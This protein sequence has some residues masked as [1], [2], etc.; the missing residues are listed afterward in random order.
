M[1]DL[2]RDDS[3]TL[4]SEKPRELHSL[5][6]ASSGI[7]NATTDDSSEPKRHIIVDRLTKTCVRENSVKS[8]LRSKTREESSDIQRS[9]SK[10]RNTVTRSKEGNTSCEKEDA[11]IQATLAKSETF[12]QAKVK[13]RDAS[14]DR[15]RSKSREKKKFD[16]ACEQ[17]MK[18]PEKVSTVNST[19]NDEQR[20]PRGRSKSQ[21]RTQSSSVRSP[22]GTKAEERSTS[23]KSTEQKIESTTDLKNDTTINTS[24]NDEQ[25]KSRGRSKS[26]SRPKSRERSKSSVRSSAS[27]STEDNERPASGTRKEQKTETIKCRGKSRSKSRD[28]RK[29]SSDGKKHVIRIKLGSKDAGLEKLL[30]TK[31]DSFRDTE[32]DILERLLVEHRLLMEE[33][34]TLS[35]A[36][37][38]LTKSNIELADDLRQIR[39]DTMKVRLANQRIQQETHQLEDTVLPAYRENVSNLESTLEQQSCTGSFE[40]S[41]R[42]LYQE[43]VRKMCKKVRKRPSEVELSE[44]IKVLAATEMA[45]ADD[46]E[47]DDEAESCETEEKFAAHLFPFDNCEVHLWDDSDATGLTL[48]E[49]G[50]YVDDNSE[51]GVFNDNDSDDDDHDSTFNKRIA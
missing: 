17:F 14:R 23:E 8:I 49:S 19:N 24:K 13:N 47:E 33:Q 11:V 46:L 31:G 37:D 22:G 51:S 5:R 35:M 2:R 32:K 25:R 9:R 39:N 44:K 21:S 42:S 26:Q 7:D 41:L 3:I 45:A 6:S 16:V 29:E 27:G 40:N 1:E 36:T 4:I 38:L 28:S 34:Q 20:K 12:D 18:N 15:K 30:S 50:V 48:D 43:A 10:S